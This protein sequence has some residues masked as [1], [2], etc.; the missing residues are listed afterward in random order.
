MN[1]GNG[2]IIVWV[3]VIGMLIGVKCENC[4]RN[5]RLQELGRTPRSWKMRQNRFF[6]QNIA[7][8]VLCTQRRSSYALN[9]FLYY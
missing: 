6:N 7:E 8:K 9:A 1:S 4:S 5:K 2:I 3:K